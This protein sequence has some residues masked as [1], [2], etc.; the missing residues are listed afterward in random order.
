MKNTN[1]CLKAR[2]K[3]STIIL[4]SIESCV[5]EFLK[6]RK[7]LFIVTKKKRPF[8][9]TSVLFKSK[10]YLMHDFNSHHSIKRN[11]FELSEVNKV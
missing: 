5:V 7:D 6:V 10:I 4:I 1:K 3:E 8:Y 11:R 2:L 9:N